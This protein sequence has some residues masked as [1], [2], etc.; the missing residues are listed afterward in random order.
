[1][2]IKKLFKYEPIPNYD[3]NIQSTENASV[4]DLSREKTDQ[5][6]YSSLQKNLEFAQSKYNSLINSDIIIRHFS[7]ICKNKQYK[8]FLLYIDGMTDSV[9]VNQFV[10]HPLMLRN[11]NNT[12]DDSTN[13][14]NT[15]NIQKSQNTKKVQN[16]Q[17][18]KNDTQ[19]NYEDL[20]NYIYERLIPNN[21]ISIQKQFDKIIS[22]INSGNCAL[23]VDTLNV[24]FDIDA[25][26]FKQRSIDRPQ[27]ENVIKGPQEA[28]VENIRTNTSLLRR[29]T[30]NENLVIENVEVGEISKTKC[31]LCYMQNIANGDLIAEAKYRLN[32]L[33]IDTLV[34]SG[35]LEQ[36]IQDGSSFGIPQVLSTERPDKCVKAVMQGRAV[37]LVNGN[38]YALII[39]SVM[40]DFLASPEDSNLNPLFANFLKFIRLLA[41]IITLLLPGMYIAVTNFHQ[42]LFP[43]ELLFSILVARE[44]VPFPIIFELLLMEISFELIREG[45]LRTP[46][47][48]GST[49]GIVGALIL[50]DAAV[51]ANIVSPILI[52]VVAI[53]GLSSFV[54]PNFS[55]GFHLRVFRFAFTILGYIAGFLGIGLGI[56]VYMVLLCSIKSFGVA[57]LSPISPNIS[58]FS[59]KYFV[60]P[61]WKQ[62]YRNDF[63]APKK[64]VSQSKFS[65]VWKKENSNGKNQ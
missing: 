19:K 6:V 40:T 11:K 33:S 18:N 3:F 44:N 49:L 58:G 34:S 30:N 65:M 23:F 24:V 50:G 45:G 13:T 48:I 5:K 56:Y 21:N 14:P 22:D 2:N 17:N 64:Q 32:N 61:F 39:P 42:E 35:E 60:P 12:F 46:S 10:L 47:A 26:G 27:I 38:P 28:F 4:Q 41:F 55:F 31:A 37:I 57:Y 16:A 1:M 20:S 52:I 54:I 59:L 7:I 36:L 63:L 15:Q 62:E 43:T 53:T 25:K 29:L 8:A 9:I 51:A